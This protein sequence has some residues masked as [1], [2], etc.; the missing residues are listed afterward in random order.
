MY[1]LSNSYH[2]KQINNI[3]QLMIKCYELGHKHYSFLLK[4]K[5]EHIRHLEARK[6]QI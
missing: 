5:I 3:N 2:K 1:S 6:N 4:W